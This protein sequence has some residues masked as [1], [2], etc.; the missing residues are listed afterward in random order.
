[1]HRYL[2]RRSLALSL[3]LLLAACATRPQQPPQPQTPAVQ[4]EPEEKTS[5]SGLTAQDLVGS[6]GTPALQI[7][8]G[9]SLK[10]QFRGPRCV[11]DAYLYP[12][13]GS[14][15]LKVTHVDTRLPSGGDIDPS[16]CIYA[17]RNQ[18]I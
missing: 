11:L 7:R 14:G 1:M 9:S 17:L 2:M 3:T 4:P 5:L 16:A 6:F 12:S 10:L 18:R 13:A 8:E 15:T